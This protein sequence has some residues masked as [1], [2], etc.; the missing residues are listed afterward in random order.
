[1]NS[2]LNLSEGASLALHGLA[3]VARRSPERTTV[4]QL[5]TALEA[6]EAHMAKVFQKLHKAG[7]VNSVR[8]PAGGFSLTESARDINFLEIY[9]IIDGEISPKVCPIGKSKCLFSKCIFTS[10]MGETMK[11]LYQNLESIKLSDFIVQEAG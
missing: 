6:S 9:R 10:K 2:L 4:K 3:M 8:G 5:A 7:V 1:M 11:K